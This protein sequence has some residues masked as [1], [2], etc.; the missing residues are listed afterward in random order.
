MEIVSGLIPSPFTVQRQIHDFHTFGEEIGSSHHHNPKQLSRSQCMS[1][2]CKHIDETTVKN[3]LPVSPPNF[4]V[5]QYVFHNRTVHVKFQS[6]DHGREFQCVMWDELL[7]VGDGQD[8]GT[9]HA[10]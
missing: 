10:E 6:D 2:I 9:L 7:N 8:N 1:R 5:Q 3:P 4:H